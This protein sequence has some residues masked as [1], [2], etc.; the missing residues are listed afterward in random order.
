VV[1]KRSKAPALAKAFVALLLG[2]QGRAI[3]EKSG[4][5]LPAAK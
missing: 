1:L 2:A 3:L 5:G 4:Y